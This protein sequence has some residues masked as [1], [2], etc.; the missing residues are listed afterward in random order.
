MYDDFSKREVS[1][2]TDWHSP[3]VCNVTRSS[4]KDFPLFFAVGV[5]VIAVSSVILEETTSSRGAPEDL[6]MSNL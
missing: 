2:L 6:T 5:S 3:E 4:K 1:S